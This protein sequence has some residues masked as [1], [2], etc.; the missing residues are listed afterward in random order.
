MKKKMQNVHFRTVDELLDWLPAEEL[1]MTNILRH[2][3]LDCIPWAKEKLSYQVPFY[4]GRKT[5]CFIWP[6]S[7]WWGGKQTLTGVQM[8]FTQGNLLSSHGDYFEKGTRKQVITR[9]FT[10][11]KEMD[12]ELIRACLY[13]AAMID[14]GHSPD[15]FNTRASLL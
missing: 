11:K 14:Q 2:Q 13:E 6:G 9:V 10:N 3:I 1:E 5:I 15:T 7:V 4:S 8:G 12:L